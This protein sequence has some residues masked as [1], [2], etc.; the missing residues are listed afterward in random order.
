LCGRKDTTTSKTGKIY[1]KCLAG[2]IL[3]SLV[4]LLCLCLCVCLCGCVCVHV[5]L[6]LYVVCLCLC[7]CVCV[8]VRVFMFVCVSVCECV[9]VCVSVCECVWV[10]VCVCLCLCVV[11]CGLSFSHF[12][13]T[14]YDANAQILALPLWVLWF[15]F[16]N[17][18]PL[19]FSKRGQ[20]VL[21]EI[22]YKIQY[23]AEMMF[24]KLFI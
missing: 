1:R 20:I 10:C 19:P 24:I 12:N 16:L 23:F 14:V 22:F 3:Q 18:F 11:N 6:I 17:F 15:Q 13:A 9:W 4:V 5:C 2:T 7:V 21:V 8:R